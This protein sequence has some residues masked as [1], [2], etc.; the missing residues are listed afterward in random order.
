MCGSGV[1]VRVC[2]DVGV[3]QSLW[4]SRVEMLLSTWESK[5]TKIPS[6]VVVCCH[7]Q[8]ARK[9]LGAIFFLFFLTRAYAI[10]F[11]KYFKKDYLYGLVQFGMI[12]FNLGLNFGFNSLGD[13]VSH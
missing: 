13:Q 5:K 2:V 8:S 4:G 7:C 1:L 12:M 11:A 3:C 9:R 6:F 10:R